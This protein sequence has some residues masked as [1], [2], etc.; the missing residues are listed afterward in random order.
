VRWRNWARDDTGR[1]I[2]RQKCISINHTYFRHSLYSNESTHVVSEYL[3]CL[4]K[5]HIFGCHHPP[6]S[7]SHIELLFKTPPPSPPRT[8]YPQS[9]MPEVLRQV[10]CFTDFSRKREI[11]LRC[12]VEHC[13]SV[14]L[15][16]CKFYKVCSAVCS[17][18]PTSDRLL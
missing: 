16:A 13:L 12:A 1:N 4:L 18:K 3:Q 17:A 11:D 14:S 10:L 8:P 15:S 6:Q 9:F 2:T 5:Y 7:R